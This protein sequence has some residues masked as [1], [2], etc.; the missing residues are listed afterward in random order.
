M[1][2]SLFVGIGISV[3]TLYIKGWRSW[4][5]ELGNVPATNLYVDIATHGQ[6]LTIPNIRI[7]RHNGPINFVFGNS[8]KT[9]LYRAM[10]ITSKAI[11]EA[12]KTVT[13]VTTTA[14]EPAEPRK[15]FGFR[16]LIIDL[17]GVSHVDV[18]GVKCIWT[19]HNEIKRLGVQLILSG[20]NDHVYDIFSNADRDFG[21]HNL[22]VLA[23]VHD[24]VLFGRSLL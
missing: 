1:S 3:I 13:D 2:Y 11:R 24:A 19:I 7:Y 15:S 14:V 16:C 23:S 8:F 4:N 17:S 21:I 5:C 20:P 6:A 9:S 10:G 22:I 18:A 12:T